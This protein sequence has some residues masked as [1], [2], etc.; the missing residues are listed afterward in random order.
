MFTALLLGHLLLN[1]QTIMPLKIGDKV[2]DL[3]LKKMLNHKSA[4]GKLSD[5]KGKAIIIDQWF[6]GCAPCVS[7][8]PKMDSLQKEFS[9]DLLVLLV[10]HEKQKD[11]EFFWANH[12]VVKGIKFTQVVEDTLVRAYFPAISFPQQ[13]WIDKNQVVVAIT[14]GRGSTSTNVKKLIAG[15]KPSLSL[16]KDEL[17]LNVRS[18]K[19]PNIISRY[20]ENKKNLLYYSYFSK[21]RRELSGM[22]FATVDT[23]DNL[24][25]VVYNNTFLFNLYDFAYKDDNVGF[26]GGLKHRNSR[27]IRK[28]H[29][30]IKSWSL[31]T[32]DN[33]YINRFCYELIY[34][35][36]TIKGFGRHMI[37]DLDRFFNLKS[38]EELL[39]VECYV[40]KPNGKGKKYFEIYQPDRKP[41]YTV[42]L[43]LAKRIIVNNHWWN[44]VEDYINGNN[45]YDLPLFIE[46]EGGDR[47]NFDVRWDTKN[48]D[49]M[50][51][52]LA[53]FD[54]MIEQATR[55]RK[56]I[57]LEDV[58]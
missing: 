3:V 28:D 35:G 57:V 15:E 9:S 26:G 37:K 4:T 31:D 44:W 58:D 51:S 6:I 5:F 21:G 42:S 33:I 25:R 49:L 32:A 23:T 2:P 8:M 18:A 53:K 30:P 11:V 14:D 45:L 13:V 22:R 34:P 38:R 20:E 39:D 16:K 54:L 56:V 1:A 7:S 17:D 48:L 43:Q 41:Y 10:N 29:N 19:Q 52:D 50:N 55:K 36:R 47:I 24:V 27:L 12:I 40:I 46:I